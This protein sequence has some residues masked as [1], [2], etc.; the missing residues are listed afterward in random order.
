[1]VQTCALPILSCSKSG[2]KN[3]TSDIGMPLS[4]FLSELIEGLTLFFSIMEMVLLVTPAR[5]A[6]SR[7]ERPLSLRMV[8]S[9]T[10]TS[11]T[12]APQSS[13]K[14]GSPYDGEGVRY[15]QHFKASLGARSMSYQRSGSA[16]TTVISTR[17]CG[18]YIIA[19]TVVRAG[20]APEGSQLSQIS[21]MPA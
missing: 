6:S 19:W 18:A 5:L 16:A 7:W 4:T 2:E 8:C 9:R 13:A 12:G 3:S 17:T 20:A 10:P 14:I 15:F 21:F 11:N 1:G